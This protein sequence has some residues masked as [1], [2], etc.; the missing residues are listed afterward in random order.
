[1]PTITSKE[2]NAFVVQK[3]ITDSYYYYT[4]IYC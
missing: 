1:M 2:K 3:Y 4:T